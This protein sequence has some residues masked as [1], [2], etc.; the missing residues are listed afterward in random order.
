MASP[1][2]MNGR[3]FFLLYLASSFGLLYLLVSLF[4]AAVVGVAA[5]D[6]LTLPSPTSLADTASYLFVR[7]RLRLAGML[8]PFACVSF[9]LGFVVAAIIESRRRN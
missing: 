9:Y 4:S 7:L 6:L 5:S 8:C 1:Q 2:D 3:R